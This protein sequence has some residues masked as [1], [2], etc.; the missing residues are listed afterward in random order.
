M[1]RTSHLPVSELYRKYGVNRAMV[2]SVIYSQFNIPADYLITLRYYR[3]LYCSGANFRDHLTNEGSYIGYDPVSH[4]V[5]RYNIIYQYC[6][7]SVVKR[8]KCA[9]VKLSFRIAQEDFN[10]EP[11]V[12]VRLK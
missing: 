3:I 5:I 7:P 1:I 2:R 12:L 6:T 8:A 9:E 11:T 4:E 10:I